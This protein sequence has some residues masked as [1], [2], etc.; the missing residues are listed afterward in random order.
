MFEKIDTFPSGNRRYPLVAPFVYPEQNPD[1]PSPA[2][3][4]LD[5]P[6]PAP[7]VSN[8][9]GK[10]ADCVLDAAIASSLATL[11]VGVAKIDTLTFSFNGDYFGFDVS[12][13]RRWLDR[14][15]GGVLT[16]GG[17]LQQRFNGYSRC[18]G[19][20]L[21]SGD[22]CPFLGWLGVSDFSDHNRGRWCLHLTG[23]SCSLLLPGAFLAMQLDLE[24][25][26]MLGKITRI[27]LAVDD[28]AGEHSVES[29]RA[30]YAA[31]QFSIGGRPPKYKD[32][33]SSDGDTFYVGRRGSGKY[34]RCYE[35]GRQLG[36]SSSPWVRHEIEF[37]A[38]NRLLPLSMLSDSDRFFKGA[39][40]IFDW[41]EGAATR[42]DTA[43]E[44][45]GIIFSAAM[46][47]AKRQVGRLLRYCVEKLGYSEQQVIDELIGEPGCYPVRLFEFDYLDFNEPG[48]QS[49]ELAF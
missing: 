45:I 47:F 14:V 11:S 46:L 8:T 37:H 32:I 43:R 18:Y 10:V 5:V 13:M 17:F 28:L 1:V 31:G 7:P 6:F 39:Y 21:V 26:S 35:K 29:V 3:H 48:L 23:V 9:G 24:L 12:P 27:D 15:S 16:I 49:V 22:F 40:D 36:D 20:A 34:Y 38:Q 30:M 44:K 4:V 2:A 25:P 41:I 33:R 19:V 42:I